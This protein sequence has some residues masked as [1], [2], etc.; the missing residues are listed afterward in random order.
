MNQKMIEQQCELD[1]IKQNLEDVL[2]ASRDKNPMA[3]RF[4]SEFPC[5]RKVL[6][7]GGIEKMRHFYQQIV[8]EMGGQ[9]DYN[10]GNYQGGINKLSDQIARCDIVLCPVDVNSHSACTT[11]K[12]YSKKYNK[13]FYMLNNSGIGTIRRKLQEISKLET[14]Q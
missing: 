8:V 11:V 2:N 13:R 5:A 14:M 4:N 1:F 9:F 10:N 3:C 7:V 6:M 12:K